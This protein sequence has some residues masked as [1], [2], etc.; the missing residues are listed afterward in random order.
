MAAALAKVL[1][2]AGG[3]EARAA[4]RARAAAFTWTACARATV[5]AYRRALE[6]AR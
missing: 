2:D 3:E 5:S 6:A 4:R 1:A